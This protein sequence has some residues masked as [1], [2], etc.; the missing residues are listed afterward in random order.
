MA[1]VLLRR[2]RFHNGFCSAWLASQ[3]ILN[4]SSSNNSFNSTVQYCGWRE[5]S[6]ALFIVFLLYPHYVFPVTAVG[7]MFV[8]NLCLMHAIMYTCMH[9]YVCVLSVWVQQTKC[10]VLM[11]GCKM[12][13]DRNIPVMVRE[14]FK[15][16]EISVPCTNIYRSTMFN[17]NLKSSVVCSVLRN[18][19]SILCFNLRETVSDLNAFVYIRE[20]FI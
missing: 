20:H 6:V 19:S 10:S 12:S 2:G 8:L 4:F 17:R 11:R 5:Q 1:F 3:C 16:L 15:G 7:D 13:V 14:I 9:V 18:L